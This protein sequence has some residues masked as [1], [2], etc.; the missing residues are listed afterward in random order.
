[1]ADNTA[2]VTKIC[3]ELLK[4]D[5][6]DIIQYGCNAHLLKLHQTKRTRNKVCQDHHIFSQ[7]SSSSRLVQTRKRGEAGFAN[8]GQMEPQLAEPHHHTYKIMEL[9]CTGADLSRSHEQ[10]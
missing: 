8:R 6:L 4:E 2:N 9:W 10:H 3:R 5:E 7:H 1:M